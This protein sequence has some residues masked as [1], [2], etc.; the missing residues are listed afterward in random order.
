MCS[1]PSLHTLPPCLFLFTGPALPVSLVLVGPALA[2]LVIVWA[3]IGMAAAGQEVEVVAVDTWEGSG[4]H[5]DSELEDSS[6]CKNY[7]SQ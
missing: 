5:T 2:L 4:L 7:K 1:P 3:V 6:A